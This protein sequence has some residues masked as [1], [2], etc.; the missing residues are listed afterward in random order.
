MTTPQNTEVT[1]YRNLWLPELIVFLVLSVLTYLIFK[2]ARWDLFFAELFYT[3]QNEDVWSHQNDPIWSFFYHG[4]PILTGFLLFGSL[5]VLAMSQL[6]PNWAHRRIYALFVFLAVLIGPGVLVN[7]IFKPYWGRPRPRQVQELGGKYE[8]KAWHQPG[9]GAQGMS[10]PCGHSSVGYAYGV[11]FWV[12]RRK[13]P[14]LAYSIMLGS[15]VLG[16]V[17]GVGRIAA[18]GHFM[19]DVIWSALM[20]WFP[21]WWLYYFG[22]R[23]P[24]REDGLLHK[25]SRAEEKLGVLFEKK[26]F[27]LSFYGGLSVATILFLLLASPFYKA[28]QYNSGTQSVPAEIVLELGPG[29]VS[30]VFDSQ[31]VEALKVSGYI[32]GFGFPTNEV[33]IEEE[34]HPS[35]LVVR[36]MKSGFFSDFENHLVV[37]MNPEFFQ[38]IHLKTHE[39]EFIMSGDIPTEK[40]KTD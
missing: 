13:R 12:Y 28:L 37:S 7:S 11:F 32:K 2:E 24:E 39:G 33:W 38:K 8:F 21:A 19:S 18:G 3:P 36:L 10:F 4:A 35:N 40:I 34:T 5:G 1:N 22:L 30:I 20:V 23:I 14:A 17:M 27:K 25:K 15:I 26:W 16:T 31:A 29:D 9:I 6:S